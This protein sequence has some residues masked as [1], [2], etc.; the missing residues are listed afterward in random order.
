MTIPT[1]GS[2]TSETIRAEWGGSY[3][4]TSATVAGWASL[5]APWTSENLR[6]KSAYDPNPDA[7]N[8]A[9]V[10][11]YDIM[12]AYG[13]TSATITGIT[14][15]ITLTVT[16]T[17]APSAGR[18]FSINVGGTN[19]VT[20]AT[21]GTSWSFSVSNGQAVSFSFTCTATTKIGRSILGTATVVNTTTGAT[22]D[23]FEYNV[24][25]DPDSGTAA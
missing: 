16:L 4:M 24:S 9:D 21:S 12:S 2:F 25:A 10:Y 15:S 11:G 6:G 13:S 14:G 19:V 7:V 23:T 1:S 22:L 17:N 8:W 20:N 3:P 18:T 5:S